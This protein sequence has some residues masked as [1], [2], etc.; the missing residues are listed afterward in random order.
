[1]ALL[2]RI[3]SS[4]VAQSTR[5]DIDVGI[6]MPSDEYFAPGIDGQIWYLRTVNSRP[7]HR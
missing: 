6:E 3:A 5:R 4:W 1:M 7:A 2:A